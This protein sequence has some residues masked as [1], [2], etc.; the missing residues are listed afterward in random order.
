M[1]RRFV[2]SI[3]RNAT[4]TS[5]NRASGVSLRLDPIVMRATEV[6]RFEEV[7]IVNAATGARFTT[8]VDEGETAEASF[9]SLRAGDVVSIASC[10]LLH[11]G[12]TLAHK[13][14]VVTLDAKNGV[15]SIEER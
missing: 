5:S 11:D 12:Q 4:A 9:V 1:I 6:L 8:F 14:R 10:A 3:V 7:E 2:R 15:V 13:V